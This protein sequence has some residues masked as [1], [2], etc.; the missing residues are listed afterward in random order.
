MYVSIVWPLLARDSAFRKDD[1]VR[2][3]T[4]SRELAPA[5][6]LTKRLAEPF[7]REEISHVGH[8]GF[9]AAVAPARDQGGDLVHRGEESV[10]G[11]IIGG[12]G[13]GG[14]CGACG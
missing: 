14:R 8:L 1:K 7:G 12:G 5:D 11:S 2:A 9:V 10:Q 13:G 4:I 3:V 6:D